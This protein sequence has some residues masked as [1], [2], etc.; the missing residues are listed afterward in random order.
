MAGVQQSL[1]ATIT[2]TGEHGLVE[3]M[4]G[5]IAEAWSLWGQRFIAQRA[6][7][8]GPAPSVLCER[9]RNE[10]LRL[11]E[12]GCI[13]VQ[14]IKSGQQQRV[15]DFVMKTG[16]FGPSSPLATQNPLHFTGSGR[17]PVRGYGRA[18]RLEIKETG[19]QQVSVTN[20]DEV[21]VPLQALTQAVQAL[22][23]QKATGSTKSSKRLR[24]RIDYSARELWDGDTRLTGKLNET[25]RSFL[26][27]LARS[28]KEWADVPMRPDEL[29]KADAN[30][31]VRSAVDMLRAQIGTER[32][33]ALLKTERRRKNKSWWRASFR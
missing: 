24:F 27:E 15:L 29:F 3:A 21:A 6:E 16:F 9:T 20:L 26:A 25:T 13:A 14:D 22:L 2:A 19:P 1:E 32:V 17:P 7:K 30:A 12:E 10:E 28:H 23:E 8:D 11:T 5:V 18:E 33:K 4:E 31:T